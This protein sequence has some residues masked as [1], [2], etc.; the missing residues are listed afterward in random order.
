MKV[1]I[2]KSFNRDGAD[3]APGQEAEFPAAVARA[4][5][6]DGLVE[7]IPAKK[8]KRRRKMASGPTENK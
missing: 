3:Y 4:L 2:L 1:K 6:D 7:L 8:K 5:A